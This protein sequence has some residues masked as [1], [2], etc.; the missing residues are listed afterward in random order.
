MLFSSSAQGK[1]LLVLEIQS[2]MV[3]GSLVF[4]RTGEPAHIMLI[5]EVAI[6]FKPNA[7]TPYFVKMTMRSLRE[8]TDLILRKLHVMATDKKHP[9]LPHHVDEIHF[10]LSSPW[11][12][13]QARILSLSFDKNTTITR[14]KMSSIL[15][16]ERAKLAP[17]DD[18]PLE[19]IE[20]KIFDVSLNGYSVEHWEGKSARELGVSYAV[21]VAGSDTMKR[22]REVCEH[23]VRK[24]HI[25][26]HSSLLLQYV[27]LRTALPGREF[28][29]L[30]HIHGELT[31]VLI[32]KHGTCVFFGS[33]PMGVNTIVRKIAHATKTDMRTADSLLSLYLGAKLNET[34]AEEVAP[35][36]KDMAAGWSAE[37]A[38][39]FKDASL[40]GLIQRETLI[41]ARTHE[42]F[43]VASF[44]AAYPE[45]H[46][47]A[48]SGEEIA[49]H[50]T[51][52]AAV[53]H[54]RVVS[55]YALAVRELEER[56]SS[57]V[58]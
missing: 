29:N 9:G 43:F 50:V 11:I 16:A 53:P 33:Y 6:A 22:L 5:E 23:A 30:V 34:Q 37:F 38:H 35:V 2:S 47:Q 27:G 15:E 52:A 1:L 24:N 17:K 13:S 46:V 44:Q 20:E 56:R 10:V 36:M 28:Y 51:F 12:A 49:S 58:L 55:A 57:N 42:D 4:C 41:A 32:V 48:W 39:L 3:R 7:G 54:Y 14:E 8:A 19:T 45:H 26:F 18:G 40:A 25:F 31:D 21:T